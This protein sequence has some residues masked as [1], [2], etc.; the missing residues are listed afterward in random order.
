[1]IGFPG[2]ENCQTFA[3]GEHIGRRAGNNNNI[4]TSPI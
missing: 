2:Y 3:V 1:M 4:T